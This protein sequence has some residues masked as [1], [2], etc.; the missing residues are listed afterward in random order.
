MNVLNETNVGS[1]SWV[2]PS[3]MH[4]E[5]ELHAGDNVLAKVRWE[6]IWG[7]KVS[8][9]SAE[10]TYLFDHSGFLHPHVSV[11]DTRTGAEV[12]LNECNWNDTDLL[13][14]PDGRQY[15]TRRVNRFGWEVVDANGERILYNELNYS[16]TKFNGHVEIT[17]K[18]HAL[19]ASELSLIIML[20]WYIAVYKGPQYY[21]S[22]YV[23]VIVH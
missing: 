23:P 22:A 18:G 20:A 10:G 3:A 12:A 19:P 8:A 9:E 4:R 14:F 21:N 15:R 6:D 7:A 5:F 1:L 13:K 2:Q 16:M 17:E 11:Q